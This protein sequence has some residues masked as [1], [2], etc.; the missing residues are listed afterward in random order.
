MSQAPSTSTNSRTLFV[1]AMKSYEKK[2]K[3]DL[4]THPI[5]TQLQS[6]NSSSDILAVLRGKLNPTINVLYTFSATLGQGVGLI[7]SPVN[8]ISAGIGVLFLAT[9][10]SDVG[11]SEDTFADFFER[12]GNFFK[13]LEFYTEVP[14]TNT[15]T[16]IIVNI[17]VEVLSVFTIA[18]KEIKQGRTK[19]PQEAVGRKDIE[20]ALKKLDRLTQ[21]EALMAAAQIL[22]L[23]R[24]VDTKVT[25]VGKTLKGVDDKIDVVVGDAKDVKMILQQTSNNVDD[26]K[27]S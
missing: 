11:A 24:T 7:F 16:D 20:D 15:M 9:M 8:F 10:D 14:P 6:C 21:E 5:A 18:T 27:C 22:K 25:G 2:T 4:H 19:I 23:T 17:M 12:I 26:L 13:R 3:T 1:S